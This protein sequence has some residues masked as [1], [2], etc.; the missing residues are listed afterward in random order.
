MRRALAISLMLL[1]ALGACKK[2][3][4]EFEKQYKMSRTFKSGPVSFR[5]ALSDSAVT[6]AERVNMLLETRAEKGWRAEL[7]KFGERLSQFGIVDYRNPQPELGAN[8]V[9]TTKR[10]YVLEPFL[11]G[12]YKIPPMEVSFWQEGDSTRHTLES[13]TIVV[14]V[15]SLL[16]ND[17]RTLDINDV[18][19]P[20]SFP[21]GWKR[22]GIIGACIAAA[23][24]L[25]IFLWRHRR[26]REKLI[27]PLPAHEIAYRKLE[28]LL[29]RGLIEQKLYREFTAE[30][31]DILRQY[32]EDR[33]ALRAPE[34]TTEEFLVEAGPGLPVDEEHKGILRE[35]LVHCDLVKFAA[36]EPSAEDVK[37]T[38]ETCREFIEMTK[39]REEVK[40]AAAQSPT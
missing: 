6:I 28:K 16:P 2:Q 12:D 24:A 26:I 40:A 7:P 31:A 18:A 35:F 9:V 23:A 4:A 34:R 20:V 10:V 8:G 29:A 15:K 13:D 25:V 19:A 1:V 32:I 38:F 21:F 17:K 14:N 3:G 22:V 37:R 36:L 5:V 39:V 30:V 33:F 11:S 27:P